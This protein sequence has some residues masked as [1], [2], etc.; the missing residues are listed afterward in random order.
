MKNC[1]FIPIVLLV[2]SSLTAPIGCAFR[3]DT[4]PEETP[5][6][7]TAED[8]A[9]ELQRK[10][11]ERLKGQV[12]SAEDFSYNVHSGEHPN[13]YYLSIV[14]AQREGVTVHISINEQ[15]LNIN[16]GE[17]INLRVDGGTQA[18][19]SVNAYNSAG[20]L[21][22]RTLK[23]I[24]VPKDMV[25]ADTFILK[26]DLNIQLGRLYLQDQ[27]ILKTNGHLLS[28]EAETIYAGASSRIV[29]FES[30]DLSNTPQTK[31]G[32]SIS[33]R[34]KEAYGF[35]TV[36]LHGLHGRNGRSGYELQTQLGIS[37]PSRSSLN[38]ADGE[39]AKYDYKPACP[40]GNESSHPLC[41]LIQITCLSHPTDGQDGAPGPAGIDG[42]DGQPGGDTGNIFLQIEKK[43]DFGLKI[44]LRP[45]RGGLGGEGTPGHPGGLGGAPGK[46]DS[47]NACRAAAK[48]KDGA[49]GP[50][51]KKGKTGRKGMLGTVQVNGLK[52]FTVGVRN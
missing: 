36:D 22:L 34:A 42:E 21:I 26:E 30:T 40:G 45:G 44:S 16:S 28:I 14:Y 23:K 13:E 20:I 4:G 51:G 5:A 17:P 39:D 46:Q 32:G 3:K 11:E 49:H 35:L 27:S 52:N 47:K 15:P 25:V 12:I 43:K 48:G 19:V 29:T 9:K 50:N 24:E 31:S 2:I 33:I 37:W 38:G 10:E 41:G 7:P 1:R 18:A 6:A 8:V